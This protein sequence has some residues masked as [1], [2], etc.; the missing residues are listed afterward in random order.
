MRGRRQ[1]DKALK[2]IV[3]T[4]D[5]GSIVRCSLTSIGREQKPRWI[6]MG[7]D[8]MQYIGPEATTD[9]TPEGVQRLVSEWWASR[10]PAVGEGG[11]GKVS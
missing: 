10:P 9:K 8:G 5:D 3:V 2:P 7:N 11:K 6:L 1:S 4:L